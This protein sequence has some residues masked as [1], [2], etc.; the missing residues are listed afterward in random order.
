MHWCP[1]CSYWGDHLRARHSASNAVTAESGN[2]AGSA[3]RNEVGAGVGA[4][5]GSTIDGVTDG[6]AIDL[7]E[8]PTGT[9][10]RLRLAGLL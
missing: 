6:A 9:F 1:L 10:A 5:D 2:L 7:L 3:D 8:E 4:V